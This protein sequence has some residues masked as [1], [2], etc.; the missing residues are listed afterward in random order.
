MAVRTRGSGREWGL[1]LHETDPVVSYW[2]THRWW[3]D[4]PGMDPG[5]VHPRSIKGSM[6]EPRWHGEAAQTWESIHHASSR[7]RGSLYSGKHGFRGDLKENWGAELTGWIP[8]PLP[9]QSHILCGSYLSSLSSTCSEGHR[10][11]M[12]L[13][14]L[15]V[16]REIWGSSDGCLVN[17][18]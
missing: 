3:L 2:L 16:F 15:F 7:A 5:Y 6:G 14:I 9:F 11:A 8:A 10:V 1:A 4:H 17:K 18:W 13:P 12:F